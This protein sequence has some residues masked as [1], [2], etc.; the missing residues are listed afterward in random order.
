[1]RE[2]IYVEIPVP[3]VVEPG[4]L[5][6]I[7]FPRGQE[8]RGQIDQCGDGVHVFKPLAWD[9]DDP[10]CICG[11]LSPGLS[12]LWSPIVERIVIPD[13]GCDDER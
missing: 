2:T 4:Q 8:P 3:V 1:M 6:T 9:D 13:Q 10:A 7:G 12:V 11:D 5:V